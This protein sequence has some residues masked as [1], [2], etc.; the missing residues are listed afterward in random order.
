MVKTKKHTVTE[1]VT[2]YEVEGILIHGY[3]HD[4]ESW[5]VTIRS[6]DIHRYRL[7][8]KSQSFG[9]ML[10]K[11]DRV[12]KQKSLLIEELQQNGLRE[13]YNYNSNE[14]KEN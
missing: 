12:L 8:E 10:D 2:S 3:I 11:V 5:Y 13:L 6:L 14:R 9:T 7:C 1:E 4:P